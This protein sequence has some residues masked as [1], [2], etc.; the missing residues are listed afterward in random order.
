MTDW[1]LGNAE[2]EHAENPRSFF[3]PSAEERDSLSDGDLARLMF[4]RHEREKGEPSGERMWVEVDGREGDEYIGTLTNQPVFIRDIGAGDK[5]RFGP[6]HVI[7]VQ[8]ERWADYEDKCVLVPGRLL[9]DDS[10]EPEWATHHPEDEERE[11]ADG[12]RPSGWDLVIG[13]ESEE[14]FNDTSNHRLPDLG[15]V[16]ERY[17]AFGDLVRSGARDGTWRRDPET[18]RYVKDAQTIK[19]TDS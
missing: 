7:A 12:R 1:Y 8:D 19:A 5:V 6:E 2:R 16:M 11:L 13:D 18:G 3:I 9:D 4:N 15:W 14:E 10:L 17:P